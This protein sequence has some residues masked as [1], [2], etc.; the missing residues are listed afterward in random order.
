MAGL[1]DH[2]GD[3]LGYTEWQEMDQERVNRF[4]D[5]TDDHNYIHVDVARAK[6][7]PFGG[8]VAHG[9]LTLALAAPILMTLLKVTDTKAGVN[10]G[11][12]KV[13]F[14]APL[15]VGAQW[16]GGAELV[17]V[18]Q[19]AGG[20]QGK[21]KVTIEVKDSDRPAMVAECLVR[22]LA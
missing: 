9:Y 2:V 14:P 10:Y 3:H 12:D 6:A 13:R 19:V 4:A 8:T 11:V 18:D 7:S 15:P 17:S 20:V 22:L 5:V 21:V 16:R 1:P